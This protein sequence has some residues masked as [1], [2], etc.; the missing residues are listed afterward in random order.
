MSKPSPEVYEAGRGMDAHNSVMR[1]IRARNDR[2]Y[3]PR[4]PTRVWL[5]IGRAHV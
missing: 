2:T 5:E 1:E 4:E 3:D